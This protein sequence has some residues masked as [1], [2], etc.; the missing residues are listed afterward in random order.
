MRLLR[1]FNE[2]AGQAELARRK[3]SSAAIASLP[4]LGIS[5]ICNLLAAIK[6]ARHFELDRG[7]VLFTTL[8][9]S[10]DLYRT[11]LSEL[12]TERGAYTER[13]AALD[14]EHCLAAA[15]TDH[16]KELNYLDR[17]ALHNLKYFTW[18]EQQGK[19]VEQLNALWS[20]SFW[21]DLVAELPRWDAQIAAFNRE[22]GVLS[23][24]KDRI[25]K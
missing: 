2:P 23:Q 22:T 8:T 21:E 4:L 7:D 15:T 5:S 20:P 3:V 10:V 14:F 18:V 9:D 13:Q 17:K 6:T 24:I 11:R 19:T 25:A 12:T 16:M 1:L